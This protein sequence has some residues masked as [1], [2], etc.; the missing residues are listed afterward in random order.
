LRIVWDQEKNRR[1]L[2]KHKISFEAASLVFDDPNALSLQDRVVEG[3]ERWRTL[4]LIH[5]AAVVVLVAHTVAEQPEQETIRI[6]SARKAT[7]R[8]G[9]V[10]E[11]ARESTG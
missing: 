5:D 9:R 8:E 10:Y 3:E 11:R 2:A 6:I 7:R 1:N 4:G